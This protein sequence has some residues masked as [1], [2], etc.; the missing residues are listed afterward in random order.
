M[1]PTH[2][3]VV[4]AR[5]LGIKVSYK[6]VYNIFR[7]MAFISVATSPSLSRQV[8]RMDSLNFS[9]QKFSSSDSESSQSVYLARREGGDSQSLVSREF[10]Y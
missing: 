10:K 4:S 2:T 5:L 3:N 8:L 1:Q 7:V 9:C 6:M